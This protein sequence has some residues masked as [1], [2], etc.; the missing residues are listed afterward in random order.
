VR[1]LAKVVDLLIV[2]GEAYSSNSKRLC[3]IGRELGVQSHLVA[4]GGGLDPAWLEGVGVVGLTA[5]ASAPEELVQSVI[6]ALRA[7]DEVTVT[8][9][10]GV[11]ENVE[12]RLPAALRPR[13][14]ARAPE[15]AE[16]AA[17]GEERGKD[18]Q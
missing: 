8:T 13:P 11:E 6:T 7:L 16:L 15:L 4:D 18:G 9:L 1:D 5:G 14:A 17:A 10:A 2:V 3:E 12:F